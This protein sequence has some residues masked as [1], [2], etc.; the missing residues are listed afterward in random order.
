[1]ESRREQAESDCASSDNYN[2]P[3]PETK[4]ETETPI[5]ESTLEGGGSAFNQTQLLRAIEVVERD[6]FAIAQ[7]FTSLFASLRHALSNA[8][9]TTPTTCNVSPTLPVEFKNLCLMQQPRGIAI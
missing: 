2:S 3:I 5:S 6:S 8:T 4:T 7:S 1:M 9:A